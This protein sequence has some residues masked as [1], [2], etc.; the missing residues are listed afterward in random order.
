M[1]ITTK[2]GE[3]HANMS[4]DDLWFGDDAKEYR[5]LI[6]S[7]QTGTI[8]RRGNLYSAP[9]ANTYAMTVSL[10]IFNEKYKELMERDRHSLYNTFYIPK[11]SGGL[12]R[13]DAPNDELMAALRELKTIFELKFGARW[14]YHTSAFAYIRN[15]STIDCVKKHQLNKS[16][17]FGKFDLHN[18]FGSSTME[19]VMRMLENVYPFAS[20]VMTTLGRATLEAA[21]SLCFL[22]GVLPQGT[23]M[24]PMLTNIMMIPFDYHME[25]ECRARNLVYTRYADDFLISSRD[26]FMFRDVEALIKDQ[27]DRI[28]APFN[29]N[30]QKTRYGSANGANWNFGVMLNKDN[31]ITIGR[32]KKRQ[33]ESMLY[34]YSKDK[35]N[36]VNWSLEDVQRLA[37]LA[38]Y[39]KMVEGDVITRIIH[40]VSEKQ[41]VDITAEMKRDLRS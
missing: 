16:K 23:P 41:G 27:L 28:C 12:R 36:G 24:S 9:P 4:L 31:Q 32:A 10:S 18:F 1:Y 39:Y 14:L 25:Q 13:I 33:F 40:H 3:R 34:A 7:N 15:R 6:T 8:T 2:A 38:S 29:L 37:G 17:W 30:T 35:K 5:G 26:Q 20:L 22:D 11:S 19:F 21:L